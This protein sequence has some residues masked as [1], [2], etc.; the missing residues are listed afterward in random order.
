MIGPPNLHQTPYPAR[1]Y[2][3]E[4][5]WELCGYE[6]TDV[7]ADVV[8][9]WWNLHGRL[10]HAF[11][12]W[13]KQS[14]NDPPSEMTG[15]AYLFALLRS[16]EML[17]PVGANV[18]QGI[19]PPSLE[20]FSGFLRALGF[21]TQM[22][23][24]FDPFDCEIVRVNQSPDPT[25][26]P[27]LRQAYWPSVWLGPL[28]ILRAGCCVRSGTDHLVKDIAE[29]STLYWSSRRGNRKRADLSDGWG[30]NSNWETDPRKDYDFGNYRI[31][32]HVKDH[33]D[34]EVGPKV[35]MQNFSTDTNLSQAHSLEVLQHRSFVRSDMEQNEIWPYDTMYVEKVPAP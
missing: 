28:L 14:I 8:T 7:F 21:H 27:L 30:H 6:G 32:N 29:N 31:W 10:H 18:D 3:K 23:T 12:D 25:V 2:C 22:P 24:R 11:L 4:L 15:D 33:A 20:K 35:L 13:I 17:L 16:I 5:Y 1:Y 34:P 19:T 9:P 26:R